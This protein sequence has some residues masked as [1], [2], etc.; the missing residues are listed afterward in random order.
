VGRYDGAEG[1]R[2]PDLLTASQALSQLSYGPF[3]QV[4]H[5]YCAADEE[6]NVAWESASSGSDGFAACGEEGYACAD[7]EHEQAAGSAQQIR[8]FVNC[9]CARVDDGGHARF[10]KEGAISDDAAPCGDHEAEDERDNSHGIS[11]LRF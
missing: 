7:D 9:A 4:L 10:K 8:I 11:D 3:L 1:D 6:S 5:A 2:T